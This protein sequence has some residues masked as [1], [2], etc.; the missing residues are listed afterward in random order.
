MKNKQLKKIYKIP[1]LDL[2]VRDRD[3]RQALVG[4]FR[5]ILDHGR[6]LLG[7][8][9]A[10]FEK[11]IAGITGRKYAVGVNSGTDALFLAL[12]CAGVGAGDEVITTS[13]SWI[14]TANAIALTGATPVFADIGSD[15]NIDP[16]G[17]VRMISKKTKA[18]VPVHYTGKVCRMDEIMK[19]A[20]KHRLIVVEDAAQSFGA[21]Y[22]GKMSGSFGDLAC[23]SMNPMKVLAA[24]GEAGAVLTDDASYRDRLVALR[25]N[26]T[27]NKETC[28]ATSLNGRIDTIQAAMLTIRLRTYKGILRKREQLAG[29]Y[30]R[31]LQDISG[32]IAL[33]QESEN[34]RDGHYTYTVRVKD[35]PGLM[36]YLEK[37]GIETKIQHPILM[38][39]QPVYRT[40]PRDTL[41]TARQAVS[42]ILCLPASEKTTLSQAAIVARAIRNFYA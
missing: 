25:Y 32:V 26:G 39:D 10:V 23:F 19:I 40:C 4:A 21:T 2:R 18:I 1:F 41:G 31:Q 8:E 3:E 13:L 16:A 11:K 38:P 36:A 28:V 22:K 35:R 42:E 7:P 29:Y 6:I 15:L 34:S 20:R 33:P 24:L 30:T 17:I 9:V 5:K 14:A 37:K 12:K 27:V